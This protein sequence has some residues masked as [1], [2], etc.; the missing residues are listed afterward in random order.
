MEWAFGIVIVATLCLYIW[1]HVSAGHRIGKKLQPFVDELFGVTPSGEREAKANPP[2]Q[3][4][5]N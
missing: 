5:A 3:P 2:T 1:S 4:K